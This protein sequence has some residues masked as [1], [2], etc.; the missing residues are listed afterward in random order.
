MTAPTT[1]RAT[2]IASIRRN[3]I[4]ALVDQGADENYATGYVER[5]VH[6]S[7]LTDGQALA[8]HGARHAGDNPAQL[9]WFAKVLQ[10]EDPEAPLG[11]P[12]PPAPIPSRESRTAG[13]TRTLNEF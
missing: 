7:T 5:H 3:L 2:A 11:A 8:A 12:T 10:V 13:A 9:S 4:Q 1:T 6:F